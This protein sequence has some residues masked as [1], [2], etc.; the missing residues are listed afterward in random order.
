M[1]KPE[2]EVVCVGAESLECRYEPAPWGIFFERALNFAAL[3]VSVSG[4]R[5]S[6]GPVT[7]LIVRLP[8]NSTHFL[9]NCVY[10]S[11][12]P[13]RVTSTRF[14]DAVYETCSAAHWSELEKVPYGEVY[15]LALDV[16]DFID[17]YYL[18]LSSTGKNCPPSDAVVVGIVPISDRYLL[19]TEPSKLLV[20]HFDWWGSGWIQVSVVR[21][22]I[23]GIEVPVSGPG[24]D[25][26]GLGG[27]HLVELTVEARIPFIFWCRPVFTSQFAQD[28]G[29]P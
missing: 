12:E 11:D 8:D 26:T 14:V 22:T 10:P 15:E 29:S 13:P 20:V 25:V 9:R 4:V 6:I 1:V 5:S 2:H 23:D 3:R 21:C 28:F 16:G 24:V 7:T 18:M 19:Y 27:E 17:A